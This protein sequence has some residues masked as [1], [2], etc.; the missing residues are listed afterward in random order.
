MKILRAFAV[1]ILV[2]FLAA[3]CSS[4]DVILDAEQI[5][6]Q[7][8]G[9][10]LIVTT[11]ATRHTVI[12]DKDSRTYICAEPPPDAAVSA[13]LNVDFGFTLLNFG[14][15]DSIEDDQDVDMEGLG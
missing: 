1:L 7:K 13:D 15:N 8:E 12:S 11:A 2:G 6:L 14:G 3:A 9:K 10:R 4:P 5:A